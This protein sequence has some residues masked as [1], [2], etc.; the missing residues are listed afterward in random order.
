MGNASNTIY[1]DLVTAK[2]LNAIKE[3]LTKREYA[4]TRLYDVS[5]FAVKGVSTIHVPHITT[6][7]GQSVT[8]GNAFAGPTG[9]DDGSKDLS[10]NLKAGNP[11]LIKRDVANQ[12]KVAILSEKS[13][14]AGNNILEIMDT[15]ILK[16]MI[17]D[18]A[19]YDGI[20]GG[21]M[22]DFSDGTNNKITAADF[23]EARKYLNEKKA[24]TSGRFCFVAPDQESN[25]LL[26]PEF[27]SADKIGKTSNMPTIEGFVGR[28]YG[29]DIILL[30]HMP[31]VNVSGDVVTS[32]GTHPVIFGHALG[33]MWGRQMAE[34][35][36]T[37]L[38]LATSDRYVPYTVYGHDE[39][40]PSYLRMVYKAN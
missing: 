12:T 9:D 15:E 16:G 6:E 29:F 19:T 5:K 35:L 39:L 26:I 1:G 13:R 37:T 25:L 18:I 4:M 3:G 17:G 31:K 21:A 32:G 2:T 20:D 36:S 33:Y 34:T 10:L 22:V 14:D 27:V 38:D 40:E 30:N 11:F 23:I 28:L 7:S 24:P 8:I